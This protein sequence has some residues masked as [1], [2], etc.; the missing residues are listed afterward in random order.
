VQPTC[1]YEYIKNGEFFLLQLSGLR[2]F[3]EGG[4]ERTGQYVRSWS[5]GKGNTQK[6]KNRFLV[7]K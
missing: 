7:T 4:N 2:A 5:S 1:L 6:N 3:Y